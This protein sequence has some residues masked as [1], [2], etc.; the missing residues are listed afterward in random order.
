MNNFK[1]F[2]AFGNIFFIVAV[3]IRYGIVN[4]NFILTET[5]RNRAMTELLPQKAI[6]EEKT[7][8]KLVAINNEPDFLLGFT[9]ETSDYLIAFM[10][11]YNANWFNEL[12]PTVLQSRAQNCEFSWYGKSLSVQTFKLCSQTEAINLGYYLSDCEQEYQIVDHKFTIGSSPIH[13]YLLVHKN[14]LGK[15]ETLFKNH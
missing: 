13:A 8:F 9:D 14:I 10:V 3:K 5:A 12:S 2:H 7:G 4:G 15:C 11:F 6:V 1:G